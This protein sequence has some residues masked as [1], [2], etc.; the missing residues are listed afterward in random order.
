MVVGF[1]LI[2]YIYIRNALATR[3]WHVQMKYGI[4]KFECF[5]L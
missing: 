5:A 1:G 4:L 3:V 2:I